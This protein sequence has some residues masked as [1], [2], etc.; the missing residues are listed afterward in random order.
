M[1]I[2]T[3]RQSIFETLLSHLMPQFIHTFV[4]TY[5]AFHNPQYHFSR[6]FVYGDIHLIVYFIGFV[7]N[8]CF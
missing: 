8:S 4:C 6:A 7:E 3:H 1:Y 5:T 2:Y